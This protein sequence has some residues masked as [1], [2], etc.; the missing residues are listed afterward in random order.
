MNKNHTLQADLLLLITASIWGFAFVAQRMA[1]EGMGPHTFNMLRFGLAAISLIPVIWLFRNSPTERQHRHDPWSDLI[2][3][4][5]LCAFFLF[6]GSVCQQ[7]GL[8][9]TTAGKAGF[10]T[11][12]YL[13]LVP[14]AIS[15]G[16]HTLGWPSW[17][18]AVLALIGLF[19]LSVTDDFRLA[20]GDGLEL[21]G[22]FFWTGHVLVVDRYS[23]RFS[24]LKL[25][26]VQVSM[27]CIGSAVLTLSME[28]NQL[29]WSGIVS[30]LPA[31][32]FA[33]IVS[34]GIAYTLQVVGQRNAPASHAAILM[35]LEAVFAAIGGWWILNEVF[36]NRAL[37]GASLMLTGMLVSQLG[38]FKVG[39]R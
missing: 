9:Y 25:S 27:V 32:L 37:V 11:G 33:G 24:P 18:G 19:L 36:D 15:L 22:A 17:A 4:G 31:V 13:V 1:M 12:L 23:T 29:R 16:R 5:A 39:V 6:A 7:V 3:Y 8:Q 21:L 34:V 35:S 30:Q 10:I 26:L 28:L 14:I 2:K 38:R 20:P